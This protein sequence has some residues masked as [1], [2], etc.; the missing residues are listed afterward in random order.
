MALHPKGIITVNVDKF[1]ETFLN[2]NGY[3]WTIHD[4]INGEESETIGI[5]SRLAERPFL[6]KAHG[7]IGK[8]IVR[9]I[10]VPLQ[11]H[12]TLQVASNNC[13]TAKNRIGKAINVDRAARL[14]ERFGIIS[15]E[16]KA[17]EIPLLLEKAASIPG[18]RLIKL[19]DECISCDIGIRKRAYLDVQ[20]L[21]TVGKRIAMNYIY[22]K[23]V[24][25]LRTIGSRRCRSREIHDL[26][27]LTYSLGSIGLREPSDIRRLADMLL[28]ITENTRECEIVA[29]ALWA[30]FSIAGY[31]DGGRLKGLRLSGYLKNLFE[32]RDFKAP[33][34]RCS[35]YLDAL[36]ARVDAEEV[37]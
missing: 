15:L 25:K 2:N 1:H 6:I 21:G 20:L 29:H 24:G 23:V 13:R 36:I 18:S 26:S 8:K 16:M 9:K 12:L 34:E 32:H 31:V 37:S 19:I 30:L 5:L 35:K 3:A 7:T 10:G 11:K 33:K 22:E 17:T 28:D 4:P 27:E 14:E